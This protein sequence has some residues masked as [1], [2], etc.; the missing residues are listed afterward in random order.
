MVIVF[1]TIICA[2]LLLKKPQNKQKQDVLNYTTDISILDWSSSIA[3]T[4]LRGLTVSIT[5]LVHILPTFHFLLETGTGVSDVIRMYSLI[6][7][8]I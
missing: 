2:N 5:L 3:L 6:E 4:A 1:L 7:T 8:L